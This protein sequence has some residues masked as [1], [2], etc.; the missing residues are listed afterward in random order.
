MAATRQDFPA[1]E[2]TAA[3]RR[4]LSI[5]V[6]AAFAIRLIVVLFTYRDLP[7]AD[8]FYERFGWEMGW[9]A[10]ALATGHGFSSPYHPWSGPT[11]LEPPLYPALLALIFRLFGVY[12]LT[13]AFVALAVNS[14]L[15]ALTSIPVYFSARYSL[16]SPSAKYAAWVWALYPF[17]IYFSA[18]RPWEYALTGLL[19]TTCFCIAQRIHRSKDPF[20]WLGWGVLFGVTALSNTSVLATLPFLLLWALFEASRS[21]GRWFLSGAMTSIGVLAVL[22]PWTVRNYRALGILCPVRDN[23]WLEIYVDNFGDAPLDNSSPPS[24]ESRPYPATD[25]VEMQRFLALGE[26]AYMAEK[27]ALALTDFHQ[28]PQYSFLMTKTLRRVIYY[29]T[30]YWSFSAKELRDQPTEPALVFYLGCMTLLMV[31]GAI[32]L[33]RGNR[34]AALPYLIVLCFFPLTYYI[35]NPLMDYRQ[36]VE[37]EVVV[38]AVAGWVPWR[39]SRQTIA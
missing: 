38:L 10:R 21:G 30:G 15:S 11:A 31:R 12:S 26:P 1:L 19:F 36:A 7:D 32:R 18:A 28:H 2:Q 9:I 5:I 25:P 29:W 23:L 34:A 17:G 16:G 20:A 13:S 6:L 33:Y 24:A 39:R 27:H 37:P 8:K 14:L 22:T 4:L 35:T 3:P